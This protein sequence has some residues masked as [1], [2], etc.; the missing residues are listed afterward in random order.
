MKKNLSYIL[1]LLAALLGSRWLVQTYRRPG[2]M[3]VLESQTMNMDMKAPPGRAPVA[4]E[5][6]SV[7]FLQPSATFTG[8]VRAWRDEE[9]VARVSGRVLRTLVYP[10]D[11]VQPGQLLV[12]LDSQELSLRAASARAAGAEAELRSQAAH[13]HHQRG[14]LE[15]R[16]IEEEMLQARLSSQQALSE[17][18]AAESELKFREGEFERSN[19]LYEQGGLSLEELQKARAD[20]A[21]ARSRQRVK[22][23]EVARARAGIRKISQQRSMQVLEAQVFEDESQ[24]QALARQRQQTDAMVAETI[25]GYTRL[26]ALSEGTVTERLVSAGTLVQ[27]G[28]VLMRLRSTHKLRLQARIP[29]EYCGQLGRGSRVSVA[30][31]GRDPLLTEI[32]SDFGETDP[33]TRTFTVEA[34]VDGSVGLRVG[35]YVPMQIALAKRKRRLTV[36]LASLQRDLNNQPFVWIAQNTKT[37]LTARKRPVQVSGAQD[38]RVGILE[39]ISPG[40]RV[41]VA[42]GFGLR[43]GMALSEVKWSTQG[44]ETLPTPSGKMPE[45]EGMDHSSMPGLAP[46]EEYCSPT[47]GASP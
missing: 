32:H 41:V 15:L 4:L 45:M 17:T 31:P 34:I 10:G 2:S 18:Q 23:L 40:D 29:Q 13:R 20:L 14:Q 36:P 27:P 47:P 7:E 28:S 39:G 44:P 25:E 46:S 38:G 8:T 1:L 16:S 19:L 5:E 21:E 9:V 37:G 35:A 33:N 30:L 42:G 11:R 26:T 24:A 43:D 6:L 3:T 22:Q 12:E